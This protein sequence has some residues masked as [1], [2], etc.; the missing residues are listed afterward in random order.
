MTGW[1]LLLETLPRVQRDRLFT[2]ADERD[3][4][5]GSTLFD[6]GDIADRFWLIR[7]GEVALDVY[8]PGRRAQVVETLGPR[9]QLG[10]S[11]IFPPYRWHLG[12]RALGTV[13]TWEFPAAEVRELC[14]AD[15]ALGYELMLR[16]AA[17]IADRLQATRLRL[18]DLYTPHGSVPS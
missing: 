4:S 12:A 3:F 2:L 14:M 6:E 16:C 11:W 9:Q 13:R 5:A 1:P 15:T 18:L 17:L 10:W 7:S 8:V